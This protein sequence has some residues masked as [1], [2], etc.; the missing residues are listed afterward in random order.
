MLKYLMRMWNLKSKIPE[1]VIT[2][3]CVAMI[4]CFFAAAV[5]EALSLILLIIKMFY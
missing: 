4:I 1:P 5:Y 3:L 2:S